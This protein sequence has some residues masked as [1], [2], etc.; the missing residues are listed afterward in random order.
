MVGTGSC[1]WGLSPVFVI[2]KTQLPSGKLLH[3][4]GKS[5]FLMGK[6]TISMA[7]FNSYVKLPEGMENMG[8]PR[9]M[10]HKWCVDQTPHVGGYPKLHKLQFHDVTLGSNR[11]PLQSKK[12]QSSLHG[13]QGCSARLRGRSMSKLIRYPMLCC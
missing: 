11:W 7:I 3:N 12:A 13:R 10:I 2:E 1:H 4:Y 6:S 8:N 5:P 9:K